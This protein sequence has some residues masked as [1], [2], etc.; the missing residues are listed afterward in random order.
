MLICSSSSAPNSTMRSFVTILAGL[1]VASASSAL[2]EVVS[3]HSHHNLA[4]QQ[5]REEVKI[6][7]LSHPLNNDTLHWPKNRGIV[8]T[9]DTDHDSTSGNVTFHVRSDAIFMATHVGTHLDAPSHFSKSGWS[10]D[11]IPLNRLIDV[12]LIVIDLSEKVQR[13]PSY[14]F[15]END[16]KK[17]NNESLVRPNTVVL[18]YTGNS[19]QWKNGYKGYIGTEKNA[20][21]D[22]M[23]TPGFGSSAAQFLVDQGVFGVGLD[24]ISADSSLVA[25]G[26]NYYPTA[27]IIFN[28]NQ[29]YI[30]ENVASELK[31]LIGKLSMRLTIA[32]LPITGGSGSPV[33]LVAVEAHDHDREPTNGA[34]S[35][36]F[37]SS[38]LLTLFALFVLAIVN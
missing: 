25:K 20:S 14:T 26:D 11:Q 32:P 23:R 6:F 12:P 36:S 27:H 29:I 16:F 21:L 33:R 24:A 30:L 22:T 7:D 34:T 10:V 17:A 15:T 18:V 13:D 5:T 1:L 35:R 37:L 9:K 3:A 31:S 8:V 38:A 28:T 4:G 2:L 19:E